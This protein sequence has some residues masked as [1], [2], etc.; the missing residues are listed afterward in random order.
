MRKQVKYGM[1][2]FLMSMLVTGL[3]S[4][5][6]AQLR[7]KA[8]YDRLANSRNLI[9]FEGTRSVWWAPDGDSYIVREDGTFKKVDP[10]SEKKS[11]Y[12]EDEKIIKEYNKLTGGDEE[13]LPFSR[14]QFIEGGKKIQFTRGEKIFFYEMKTSKMLS[15]KREKA[16]RGVRGRQYREVYSPDYKFRAYTRD[17]NLYIKDSNNKETQLTSD[18]HEDLRNAFPDWVYPE[19]LS[20]YTVF[21]W[22]PDSRRIAFMQFDEKQV[23]KYP[24]VHD[25]EPEPRLEMESYPKAGEENPIVKFFIVDI[26]TKKIIQVNTGDKEDI[27]LMR[28]RWSDDGALFY[29]QRMNR[30]QNELELFAADP[31]SGKSKLMFKETESCYIKLNFDQR[32]L[33]TKKQFLWTSERTGWKEIYLYDLEGNLVKQ[34]T[35]AKLPVAG[36]LTVNENTGWVYFTGYE[37]RGLDSHLYRVKLDGTGFEKLTK[38]SGSHR[39]SMSNGGKYYTDSFQSFDTPTRVTLHNGEGKIIRTLGNST[40]TQ[41][42][43]DLKLAKPEHVVIKAADGTTDLDAMIWKPADFDPGKQYPLL[44]SVYGGPGAR[45]IRNSFNWNSRNQR[46]AQLGFIIFSQDHRGVSRR[47]KA[48]ETQMYMKLGQIEVDDHE[49]GAKF[50]GAKPYVDAGRVGI[51]GHSYGGYLT[52]MAL[53]KKP[54]VFHVGVSGAPVTDWKNYDSIYTERYMRRPVDNPD[55]YKKNSCMNFAD[56]LKGKLFIHH[57]AVDDNVHPGNTIQLIY[58]LLQKGKRFDMMLY[59]EQ[60]HGIRFA[61]YGQSRVDYFVEHLKPDTK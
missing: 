45:M 13:S 33:K 31:V 54:E 41:E 26:F 6:F 48:F 25:I 55:G 43:K 61:Q 58:A 57:G 59:P 44:L 46:L 29:Y 18:G 16:I 49:A 10:K 34:L 15:F 40:I 30:L 37:T 60:Q 32:F 7:G 4:S 24:I 12:F 53:L 56:N 39:I 35:D 1:L 42:F 20:Q 23:F 21:W 51:Y 2:L 17:Y 9:K 38:E 11:S 47:G 19:E 22:S 27:Y 50:M 52:C 14:F 5:S 28:G 3:F 36:I 8:L